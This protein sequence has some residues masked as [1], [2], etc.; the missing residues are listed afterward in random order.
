MKS[1]NYILFIIFIVTLI[2]ISL[3]KECNKDRLKELGKNSIKTIIEEF[4]NYKQALATDSG[5]WGYEIIS[6][7]DGKYG[8]NNR[9][10]IDRELS[11]NNSSIGDFIPSSVKENIEGNLNTQATI[12]IPDSNQQWRNSISS[13][14]CS[15]NLGQECLWVDDNGNN[16]SIYGPG[17]FGKKVNINNP[18]NY[19]NCAVSN[20]QIITEEDKLGPVDGPCN[21]YRINSYENTTH[22]CDKYYIDNKLN[23]NINDNSKIYAKKIDIKEGIYGGQKADSVNSYFK[24]RNSNNSPVTGQ[25]DVNNDG[26]IVR[27]KKCSNSDIQNNS[28]LGIIDNISNERKKSL[29]ITFRRVWSNEVDDITEDDNENY[30][31]HNDGETKWKVEID[32]GNWEGLQINDVDKLNFVF[33]SVNQPLSDINNKYILKS[34]KDNLKEKLSNFL[35]YNKDDIKK[36][37]N[38]NDVEFN[39]IKSN[40]YTDDNPDI[41]P[42]QN[43]AYSYSINTTDDGFWWRSGCGTRKQRKKICKK[44]TVTVKKTQMRQYNGQHCSARKI[45]H[46]NF[47]ANDFNNLNLNKYRTLSVNYKDLKTQPCKSCGRNCIHTLNRCSF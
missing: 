32:D 2:M 27:F 18:P 34:T 26:I 1:D 4:S 19:G 40:L 15:Y 13:Y 30:S 43:C 7:T 5:Q 6:I 25:D 31:I 17:K 8:G 36:L 10:I 41:F 29:K 16:T 44:D 14:D 46:I 9:S 38:F 39:V 21:S 23:Y 35:T 11:N 3:L 42:P 24:V 28:A 20:G 45:G 33:G 12:Y 37:L 22:S 47:S